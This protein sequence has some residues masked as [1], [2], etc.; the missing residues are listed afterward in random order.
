M[1]LVHASGDQALVRDCSIS[2]TRMHLSLP[3][4]SINELIT[5]HDHGEVPVTE[6]MWFIYITSAADN[7]APLNEHV[8]FNPVKV[9]SN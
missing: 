4:L 7:R 9:K 8:K 5:E 2:S 6:A 1:S 3:V